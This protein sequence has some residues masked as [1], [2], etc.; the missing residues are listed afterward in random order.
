[1]T[2]RNIL[3]AAGAAAAFARPYAAAERLI[4]PRVLKAGDTVGLIT[5]ATY[6]SDPDRIALAERTIR[7]FDLKAKIGRNVRK[8]TG[9]VGGTP[10]E[11]IA[12]LHDMFRDPDVK[13]V[14][15]IRGGYGSAHLLD[16]IDYELIRRNPKIFLGYSDITSMHLAIHKQTGL[17]TFHGPVVLSR[18]TGYTQQHFRAALFEAKPLGVLTNPPE[19]E[20]LRPSHTLRTVR[21]GKGRGPL[22]GGNLSL[23]AAT[24]GTPYE[25]DTKG[26]IL[27]IEDV[28]E[29]PYEVDR[30]LTQL[31]LAGKLQA[32]AGIIFGECSECVPRQF[33]PSF[34]STFSL[35]EVVDA[36]LGDLKIPVLSGLTIGHTT[37]QLTLPLGV[38]ALLDADKGELTIEEAGVV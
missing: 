33:Q 38:M 14:F 37:D 13:A 30:M 35:G 22:I 19:T 10:E 2:R 9:Y 7:Y 8:R 34:E 25:I 16:R 15:C 26:K 36:I 21:P 31:R 3:A 27:F 32:A 1:M 18:F 5:P 24:M 11:R 4:K 23:I 20:Q 17:V 29:Q 12:D 6:V 28:G